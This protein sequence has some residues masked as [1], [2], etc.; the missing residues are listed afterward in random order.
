MW[1][2]Q[3]IETF[4]F[5]GKGDWPFYYSARALCSINNPQG[6][7]VNQTII[8]CL[9]ANTNFLALHNIHLTCC[10]LAILPAGYGLK[11]ESRELCHAR[12]RIV[13]LLKQ[14]CK[15]NTEKVKCE[16]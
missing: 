10:N 14:L 8:E 4:D 7:L 13:F 3:N 15:L 12:A 16:M 5:G 2:T 1:G 9:E 6:R 11:N